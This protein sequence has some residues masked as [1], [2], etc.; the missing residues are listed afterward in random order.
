MSKSARRL[1]P[2]D[3]FGRFTAKIHRRR[4]RAAVKGWITR[5]ANIAARARK[6]AKQRK[7]RK[8]T[9]RPARRRAVEIPQIPE[10][11][12]I[13]TLAQLAHVQQYDD[14]SFEDVEVETSADY[15]LPGE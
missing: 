10:S 14:G 7:A 3:R 4:R 5:R 6:L 2:R 12:V 11:G 13:E 15:A 8:R 9:R 1:P